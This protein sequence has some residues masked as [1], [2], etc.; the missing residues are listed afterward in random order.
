MRTRSAAALLAWLV[1][2][3]VGVTTAA[4]QAADTLTNVGVAALPGGGARI[5]VGFSGGPPPK[6]TVAGSG[7]PRRP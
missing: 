5:T 4:A 7:T 6:F 1:P 2:F 3:L